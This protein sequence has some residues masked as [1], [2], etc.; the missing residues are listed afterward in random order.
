[1]WTTEIK[2]VRNNVAY[3]ANTYCLLFYFSLYLILI[4][5]PLSFDFVL[6]ENYTHHQIKKIKKVQLFEEND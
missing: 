4:Q 1:M 5:V 2:D 3:F 6:K